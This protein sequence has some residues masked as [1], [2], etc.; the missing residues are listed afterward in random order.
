MTVSDSAI[1]KDGRAQQAQPPVPDLSIV[2]PVYRSQEM[3]VSLYERLDATL[4]AQKLNYEIIFVEDCGGDD[5]WVTIQNL[6]ERSPNVRGIKLSRNYGQHNALLCGIRGARAPLTITIDDDLQHPPEELPKLLE[7][8]RPDVDVVYGAPLRE[9]HGFFRGLASQITKYVLQTAM[10]AEA[11]RNVSAL[12]VFRT[13]L[14]VA[15]EDHNNP[16]VNID[17]MLT[18]ATSRFEVVRVRHDP[19]KSGESGYTFN[20]LVR[21]AF[22]MVTGFSTLPLKLASFM[23]LAFAA[24]GF[25]ILAYVLLVYLIRGPVV[26]GFAFLASVIALFSGVQLLTIGIIGEYLAR[27]HFRTMDKPAFVIHETIGQA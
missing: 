9:P 13:R 12:R 11:A 5:S 22:N 8:M 19:R 2:V 6:A 20:L 14:R 3:L 23:G 25:L 15:F 16:F 4:R 7:A 10:G 17:V 18:W 24:F 21:H 27:I 26:P 1:E